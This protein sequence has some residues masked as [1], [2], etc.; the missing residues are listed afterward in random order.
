M[1]S[2]L[3]FKTRDNDLSYLTDKTKIKKLEDY[4]NKE[5]TEYVNKL[6]VKSN[7]KYTSLEKYLKK[8]KIHILSICKDKIIIDILIECN[9][10]KIINEFLEIDNCVELLDE[11][12]ILVLIENKEKLTD[13]NI[14]KIKRHIINNQI[15]KNFLKELTIKQENFILELIPHVLLINNNLDLCKFLFLTYHEKLLKK[16]KKQKK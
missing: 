3:G 11:S 15:N 14:K 8:H 1:L 4:Q 5:I 12:T 16:L 2:L 13:N 9:L 10:F 7:V 6:V